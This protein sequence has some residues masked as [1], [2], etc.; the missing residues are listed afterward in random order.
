MKKSA[1]LIVF[2]LVTFSLSAQNE[3]KGP[4][5]EAAL[6]EIS[7]TSGS[8]SMVSRWEKGLVYKVQILSSTNPS[9]GDARVRNLGNVYNYEHEGMT[10]YTWGRTRLA[11]EAARLQGEMHRNGF[12][13]A[14][15]VHFYN[16]KRITS[17]EAKRIRN[18]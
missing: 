14:F 4:S 9:E 15:I 1:L 10:K 7:E 13:D 18:K 5:G 3:P 12:E 17:E 8:E 16:G 2:I 11:E 6:K